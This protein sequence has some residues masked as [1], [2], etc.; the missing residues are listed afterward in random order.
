MHDVRMRASQV[1]FGFVSHNRHDVRI[2]A[3]GVEV[4]GQARPDGLGKPMAEQQDAA[5]AHADLEQSA[6]FVLHPDDSVTNSCNHSPALSGQRAV[7]TDVEEG[8]SALFHE[9]LM[10]YERRALIDFS[11]SSAQAGCIL[12]ALF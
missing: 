1:G 5:P 2:G 12:P 6:A 11:A 9:D 4:I 8:A 7:G 10:S 3:F